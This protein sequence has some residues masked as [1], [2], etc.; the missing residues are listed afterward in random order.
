[1]VRTENNLAEIFTRPCSSKIAETNLIR[2]KYGNEGVLPIFKSSNKT[3]VS[4]SGPLGPLILI[5]L[6]YGPKHEKTGLRGFANN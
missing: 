3:Q 1:M 5:L 2:K 4:D 6:A